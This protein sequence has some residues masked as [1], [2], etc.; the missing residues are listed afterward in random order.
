MS[1]HPQRTAPL[2]HTAKPGGLAR[3][4]GS[5]E[6]FRGRM[7]ARQEPGRQSEIFS[8]HHSARHG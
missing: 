3:N 8:D 6:G 7:L 4:I 5:G 1:T 2:E